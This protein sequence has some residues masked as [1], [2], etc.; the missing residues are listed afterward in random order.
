MSKVAHKIRM[1]AERK[2]LGVNGPITK[3]QIIYWCGMK[4]WT[5]TENPDARPCKSCEK[6]LQKD[7]AK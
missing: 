4:A 1:I 6:W 2:S 5:H 7:Q 3:N